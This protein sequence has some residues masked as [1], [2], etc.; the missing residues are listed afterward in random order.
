MLHLLWLFGFS[1]MSINFDI[2]PALWR[3]NTSP[4]QR[5]IRD[6]N[7]RQGRLSFMTTQERKSIA[8]YEL[9]VRPEDKPGDLADFLPVVPNAGKLYPRHEWIEWQQD[10]GGV[11][12][13]SVEVGGV[14]E[15]NE[16]AKDDCGC[17]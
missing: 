8:G 12:D 4:A 6:P 3:C 11:L 15:S 16:G 2:L 17:L 1:L 9:A 5:F 7:T 13:T 10:E 14:G